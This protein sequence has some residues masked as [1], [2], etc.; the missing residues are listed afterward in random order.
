MKILV[1]GGTV[2]LGR[3]IVEAAVKRGHRVTLFNRGLHDPELFPDQEKLVGDRNTDLNALN[4]RYFDAVIDP[5]AYTPEHI[6]TLLRSLESPPER[7]VFVSSIS[8]YQAVP[9]GLLYDETTERTK[10]D[11]G[12]GGLKARA[13]DMLNNMM[14]GRAAIVRPGLI[15]GPFDP[16]ERFTYWIRRMDAGGQVLAPGRPE[17]PVQFIDARDLAEW[18]VHLAESDVQGTFNAV[19]PGSQLSMS[20]FLDTCRATIQNDAEL[21]WLSDAD[22]IAGE[23]AGWTEMPLWL[24]EADPEDGGIFLA[25]NHLAMSNGLR[26]RPL[27]ETIADTLAWSRANAAS[28]IPEMAVEALAPRK[29]RLLLSRYCAARFEK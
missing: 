2:F 27:T 4:G 23:V 1:M 24:P 26:F 3:H 18:T 17:R 5:S 9:P 29:E 12:Y 7:Y 21:H 14:P 25:S 8:V 20:T 15:A 22:L 10:D 16:T 6:E 19:G 11:A 13:E 28:R